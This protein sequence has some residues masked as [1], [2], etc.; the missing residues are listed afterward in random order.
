MEAAEAREVLGVSAT[1]EWSVVRLRYKK[2]AL[3]LHPD[4]NPGDADAAGAFARLRV[5]YDAL[6]KGHLAAESRAQ[7]AGDE[8]E[9]SAAAVWHEERMRARAAATDA[10][11]RAE[12]EARL[13]LFETQRRR[14]RANASP[15][16][17]AVTAVDESSITLAWEPPDEHLFGA[18]AL[19][20]LQYC[21]VRCADGPQSA[22][23]YVWIVASAGLAQ[24]T[25]RKKN[26]LPAHRYAFRVRAQAADGL[27]SQFSPPSSPAA[28][29]E[30]PEEMDRP[31]TTRPLPLGARPGDAP[32]ELVALR[33]RLPPERAPRPGGWQF[34]YRAVRGLW[35]A[36]GA[37]ADAASDAASDAAA[38]VASADAAGAAVGSSGALAAAASAPDGELHAEQHVL[39][40]LHDRAAYL[41]RARARVTPGGVW[42]CWSDETGPIG[43]RPPP[44]TK[45]AQAGMLRTVSK[46]LLA[47]GLRSSAKPPPEQ[48]AKR[49]ADGSTFVGNVAFGLAHGEGELR[50]ASGAVCTGHFELDVLHGGR[51]TM[52]EADGETR[53]VGEWVRG[54]RHGRGE[55]T[56]GGE[57][58]GFASYAGGWEEGLF[59][60]QGTLTMRTGETYMGG[61]A[62]GLRAGDGEARAPKTGEWYRGGWAADRY[63]GKGAGR[64][65]HADGSVY[66]G[67][68]LN[69]ARH[70]DGVL[71]VPPAT[72]GGVDV[73]GWTYKGRF[74]D[75]D[76]DGR[77]EL[78]FTDGRRHVGGFEAGRK[79]GKGR[80]IWAGGDYTDG[81][82]EQG[83]LVGDSVCRLTFANGDVYEG[84]MRAGSQ[85]GHGVYTRAS[86]HSY[87]GGWQAGSRHGSGKS[88]SPNGDW[89]D[90]GWERDEPK[91]KGR[92]RRTFPAGVYEG[93]LLDNQLTGKGKF[94]WADGRA[95]EGDWSSGTQSGHGVFTDSDGD[96]YTGQFAG[97]QFHGQGKLHE[98][99]GDFFHGEFAGGQ[100]VG[101]GKARITYASG[102]VYEGE[103]VGGTRQGYGTY[104]WRSSG[105]KY[106]G[107]WAADKMHGKG[108][109]VKAA[110]SPQEGVWNA[111]DF[112]AQ[113]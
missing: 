95:Y 91:G 93:A 14:A 40:G 25:A 59:H 27:W 82:W 49:F 30:P 103:V 24:R 44:G 36:G 105:D 102:D 76:V 41:L 106:T 50:L 88:T 70:G 10:L 60:G 51:G 23:T 2:L 15:P 28:P 35:M 32:G 12:E 6:E 46:A 19:F 109:L 42:S 96:R 99:G 11:R 112:V 113:L 3:K 92:G 111:G 62:A 104:T 61:W 57:R 56:W 94:V 81:T 48:G 67:E 90:G 45:P 47:A 26:L 17:P 55:Q 107:S 53:Y 65:V 77:G 8:I 98:A 29:G 74:R 1:D 87:S 85:E 75:N 64:F 89:Y 13:A 73:P 20:E 21:L 54:A 34:E 69:G 110:G 80:F 16:K 68:T 63:A 84:G 71:V 38:A 33:C 83:E 66:E 18:T 9:R 78:V 43:V 52:V 4:K 58:G 79:H 5:A 101:K 86:G 7:A 37:R 22:W 97:G 100:R 108:K 72:K 31:E 39:R